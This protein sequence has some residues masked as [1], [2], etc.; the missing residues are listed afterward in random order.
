M[1]I[2][3]LINETRDQEY[4][5]EYDEMTQA[6]LRSN[7]VEEHQLIDTHRKMLDL[8]SRRVKA[9]EHALERKWRNG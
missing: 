7:L 3:K 4:M 9:I 8:H 5:P 2:I 6:E 1:S